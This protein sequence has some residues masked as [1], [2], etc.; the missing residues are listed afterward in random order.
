MP[1]YHPLIK[2]IHDT[3]AAAIKQHKEEQDMKWP[4]M[5]SVGI[6]SSPDKVPEK[7]TTKKRTVKTESTEQLVVPLNRLKEMLGLAYPIQSISL[8]LPNDTHTYDNLS[9]MYTRTGST[10]ITIHTQQVH[11]DTQ[12]GE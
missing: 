8:G 12:E 10:H 9:R 11:E 1:I 5:G 4:L 3:I 6:G 7:V 2:E